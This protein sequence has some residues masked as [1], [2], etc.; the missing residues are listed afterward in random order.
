MIFFYW[1]TICFSYIFSKI[2]QFLVDLIIPLTFIELILAIPK[3]WSDCWLIHQFLK[4]T[5]KPRH[6]RP[7]V[8][9]HGQSVSSPHPNNINWFIAL[10]F[11]ILRSSLT[12]KCHD[13]YFAF[14]LWVTFPL[15]TALSMRLLNYEF[16]FECSN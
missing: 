9:R 2:N 7:A 5:W 4:H 8:W 3:I 16:Q 12:P 11:F 6:M 1:S 10:T 13:D 15:C 14:V